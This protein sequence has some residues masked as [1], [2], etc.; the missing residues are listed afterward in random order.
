MRLSRLTKVAVAAALVAAAVPATAAANP[1]PKPATAVQP[2][3]PGRAPAAQQALA[4]V[5]EAF[6]RTGAAHGRPAGVSGRG[7]ELTMELLQLRL[8]LDDLSAQD[9][10]TARGYLARPTDGSE[11]YGA[12]YSK[13]ANPTNDCVKKPTTGSN[14]CVH[15]ARKSVDAPPKADSDDDGLPNQVEKTREAMNLVWSRIVDAGGYKP[16]LPDKKGPDD[17]LD[18]YLV[19][20]GGDGLYGYCGSENVGQGRAATAYCVLDDDYARKQFPAH[21]PQQNLQV[22]AAHEFFHAVQFAYDVGEDAWMMETTA[23]WIEDEIY[24]DVN[25]NR[26][27]LSQ[28]VLRD[29]ERPLDDTSGSYL[30]GNW[31]WWRYLTETFPAEQGTGLPVLV[32][33]VWEYA[34]HSAYDATYSMKALDRALFDQQRDLAEV[35]AEFAAANRT[36]VDPDSDVYEEGQAYKRAPLSAK[37]DLTADKQKIGAKTTTL[38][39]MSNTTVAFVPDDS[40]SDDGWTLDVTVDL[41]GSAHEPFAQLTVVRA[42][43]TYS[44]EFIGVTSAGD[45]SLQVPFSSSNVKRVELTLTAGDHSYDCGEGTRWSCRG[46]PDK[47]RAF[48]Y[49]ATASQ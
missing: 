49:S 44:R 21:T 41:P 4:A 8:G 38:P 15:W 22:T 13:D 26:F 27:Y 48:E 16:P 9:Q 30:Y 23:T 5:Q 35:F 17:R 3:V 47:K 45:G 12:N 37:H 36:P 42:N 19:D 1:D 34:D 29:P 40:Y 11:Y 10:V 18:V 7:G 24:D 14:V 32:R 39:H 28:S 20:I 33:K 31:I 2:L 6:G 43:G 25:D 46:K